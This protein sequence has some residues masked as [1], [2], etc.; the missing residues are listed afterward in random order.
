MGGWEV[1]IREGGGW[2]CPSACVCFGVCVC[3][4]R[5]FLALRT[6]ERGGSELKKKTSFGLAGGGGGRSREDESARRETG[7]EGHSYHPRRPSKD[8]PGQAGRSAPTPRPPDSRA[9][10]A[11]VSAA[12]AAT[13]NGFSFR[14]LSPRGAAG[15]TGGTWRASA[16]AGTKGTGRGRASTS[17]T[18]RKLSE[19]PEMVVD[20]D[21]EGVK[22]EEEEDSRILKA[23]SSLMASVE[24]LSL[25]LK[26]V[27]EEQAKQ[28]GKASASESGWETP[29]APL[30]VE[31]P[32]AQ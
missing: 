6:A 19:S 32:R 20:G 31:P 16:S 24:K 29:G 1:C 27:K 11:P 25:E 21:G 2:V 15:E 9:T 26:E 4:G 10:T 17:R 30:K 18:R 22:K 12:A 23:M 5:I 14:L 28:K 7:A 8:R 3:G 13:E